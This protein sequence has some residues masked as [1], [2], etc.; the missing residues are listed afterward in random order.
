MT[1]IEN[2]A[3]RILAGLT[4]VDIAALPVR[5]MI[6]T[7]AFDAWRSEIEARG[8]L[9]TSIED[10]PPRLFGIPYDLGW[11]AQR[12]LVMLQLVPP[13]PCTARPV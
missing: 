9:I 7:D 1:P 11:P 3:R 6:R 5:W 10:L 12:A 2:E 4:H 13:E 8:N